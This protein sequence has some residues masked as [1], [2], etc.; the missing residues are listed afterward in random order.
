MKTLMIQYL[1]TNSQSA[2]DFA[3][4]ASKK[5]LTKRA[6]RKLASLSS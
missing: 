3:A 6:K 4:N 1:T 2:Q 5:A